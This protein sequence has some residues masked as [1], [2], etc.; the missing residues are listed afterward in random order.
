MRRGEATRAAGPA[1][2]LESTTAAAGCSLIGPGTGDGYSRVGGVGV[3]LAA[4]RV[5]IG[6]V[7]V[8]DVGTVSGRFA[9]ASAAAMV[10]AD[11]NRW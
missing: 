6:T 5:A 4:R 9:A 11:S 2:W 1:S 10:E 8:A 7:G 3:A